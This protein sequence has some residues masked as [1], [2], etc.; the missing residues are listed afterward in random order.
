[1]LNKYIPYRGFSGKVFFPR[2]PFVKSVFDPLIYSKYFQ[3]QHFH[4]QPPPALPPS[5]PLQP[6]RLLQHPLLLHPE[7]KF[8]I[9]QVPS[10]LM[11]WVLL[12]TVFDQ[13]NHQTCFLLSIPSIRSQV[14]A[15]RLAERARQRHTR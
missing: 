6:L 5:L 3:M 13:N 9:Q 4:L 1:M 8:T 15:R 11:Q 12:I 14:V 7:E 2:M 10:H